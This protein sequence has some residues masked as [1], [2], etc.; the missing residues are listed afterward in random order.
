MVSLRFQTSNRCLELFFWCT[1]FLPNVS[2][3]GDDSDDDDDDDDDDDPC[4]CRSIEAANGKVELRTHPL[5]TL[6]P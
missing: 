6:F 5:H 3:A 1:N 4:P 2:F